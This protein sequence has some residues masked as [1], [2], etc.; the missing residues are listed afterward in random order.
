M[1]TV[2][3]TIAAAPTSEDFRAAREAVAAALWGLCAIVE[4]S[5]ERDALDCDDDREDEERAEM[6]ADLAH[7]V[8]NSAYSFGDA[9]DDADEADGEAHYI[10]NLGVEGA[11]EAVE[12]YEAAMIRARALQDAKGGAP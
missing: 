5:G 12:A 7:R 2:E 4:P 10:A 8:E 1:S 9:L 6:L 3:T 11:R